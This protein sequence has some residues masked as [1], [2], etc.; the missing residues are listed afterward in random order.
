MAERKQAMTRFSTRCLVLLASLAVLAIVPVSQGTAE[1][2]EKPRLILQITV[3]SLRGDMP[4]RYY[5]RL[6]KGGFRY[7]AEKGTVY[8]NAHHRHANTETI[9]GHATLATGADPSAHGMIGNVW[10]DRTSGELTYNVEDAR[11]PIL[12]KGAGVDKKT[13]I[14]PTQ[15]TASS[16]GRSPSAI[17]VST[18]SDE[19]TLSL[20]GKSKVFG[21]SVKDRGAISMAGHTGK[22]FWFSKKSGEFIT[23][24]FYYDKYPKWVADWN[25]QKLAS[26]YAGK[27][28]QLLHDQSTYLFGDAD[29]RPYETALPG[30]GRVFPHP[31][32][33]LGD[34]YFTTLLTISP[35]GD[36][37]TLDFAKALIRNE[38]L[39]RDAIPDY[40]SVSFSS[41]DYV[42]HVF[43]PSSLESEDNI[44]QLDRTLAKLFRFI[45]DQVGLD[46]TFIVLS[47]D[48]GGPEAPGYLAELGFEASYIDPKAFDKEGAIATLKARFGI[49]KELIT[50]YFHPY[51]YLN[52]EEIRKKGLDQAEVEKAVVEELS[53][54]DGVALAV[55]SRALASGGLPDT[56]LIRSV[57]RNFNPKRSGDIYLV[58]DTNRFINDFDGLTVAATHGSPWRYDTFVPIMFAGRGISTLQISRRVETVDIAP[59][60]SSL[61]DAK[62]PSGSIGS[63]L[64]EVLQR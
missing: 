1:E 53:R 30:Y 33:K 22:A 51:L 52:R 23:S 38:D 29:D 64:L 43:G 37:L 15:R 42:G 32:G 47:S 19:L 61:V 55:S 56:P 46:K 57:L 21:V 63:P 49:G 41:T 62:P 36:E 26:K 60:L 48:H 18:F 45:D 10:L 28:W 39:G 31:F 35:A 34:K 13:E 50:T 24:K 3:D 9:V 54:F 14:D 12:S 16:D 44:L 40:L 8:R 59:T 11:Y 27:S 58:F 4:W 5:D 17:L 2:R 6:G 20:G 25:A 7:L